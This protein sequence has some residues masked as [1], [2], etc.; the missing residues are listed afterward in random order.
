MCAHVRCRLH[1]TL[2]VSPLSILG[3]GVCLHMASVGG[4]R[5]SSRDGGCGIQAS[6][7]SSLCV[8]TVFWVAFEL[9]HNTYILENL[10]AAETGW[11]SGSGRYVTS[12][13][14]GLGRVMCVLSTS[15]SLCTSEDQWDACRGLES[16]D[17]SQSWTSTGFQTREIL[18][19]LH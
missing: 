9:L 8:D 19:C 18:P 2:L 16:A 14:E 11:S 12:V 7:G 1:F 17:G 10:N 6:T 5:L 4:R 3:R 13:E 15:S